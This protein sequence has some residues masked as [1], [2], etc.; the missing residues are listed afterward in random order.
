MGSRRLKNEEIRVDQN[1]G[2]VLTVTKSYSVKTTSENFFMT[3][4]SSLASFYKI[5][6]ITDVKVL[7]F[8]CTNANFNSG[9]VSLTAAKRKELI[10]ELKLNNRQTVTNS[11]KR[12]KGLGLI[13]GDNGEYDIDPRVFWK[14]STDER[15]KILRRQGLE[16]TMKFSPKLDDNE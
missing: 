2:E 1:T 3:F 11:L 12:L 14:G 16:I 5:T 6:S 8:L 15:D 7:T 10:D 4:I 9:H 13:A